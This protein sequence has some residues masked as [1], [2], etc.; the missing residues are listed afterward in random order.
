[1]WEKYCFLTCAV[2]LSFTIG[3]NLLA[4]FFLFPF[5]NSSFS[6]VDGNIIQQIKTKPR[7][8]YPKDQ[9]YTKKL[10]LDNKSRLTQYFM[11]ENH[12]LV[13]TMH[14]ASVLTVIWQPS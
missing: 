4:F 10:K 14:L 13:C 2:L 3:E 11:S 1:M 6:R 7:H 8:V 12:E 5:W 9:Y